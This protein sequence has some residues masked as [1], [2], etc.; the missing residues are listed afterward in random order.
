VVVGYVRRLGVRPDA[1]EAARYAEALHRAGLPRQ[2]I[3][4]VL[5][6][7]LDRLLPPVLD[8]WGGDGLAEAMERLVDA[9]PGT[10]DRLR[11]HR[12]EL[13]TTDGLALGLRT[14]AMLGKLPL[15]ARTAEATAPS[16]PAP[17]TREA[18]KLAQVRGLL[19]KAESTLYDE[20]AEALSAKAQELISKY[21][22]EQ[23][24]AHALGERQ[25]SLI[26]RRLWLDA[27]YVDAKANLVHQV[28][29]ANRCR[30]VFDAPIGMCTLVGTSFDLSAVDLLVTSL[31]AQVQ[32]AMLHQGSRIDRG[33]RSRTR[34]FR[35]SFLV[36]F[37]VHIG[38]RLRQVAADASESSLPVLREHDV[39]VDALTE[40]MFPGIVERTTAVTSAEGW[41]GGRAAAELARLDAF[42]AVR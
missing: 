19:A 8:S 22:L 39:R 11:E 25:S 17:G 14:A 37:A 34:S 23:L 10:P 1:G 33:G 9:P 7:L 36:S 30:S 3:A 32:Q 4:T 13:T 20:E 40:Q 35:Q 21:S 16:G 2:A 18:A 31:L 27:P 12:L 24:L 29:L 28:A 15:T 38:D 26:S 6:D 42:V 41:A 5:W